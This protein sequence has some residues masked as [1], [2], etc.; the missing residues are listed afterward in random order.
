MGGCCAV[1]MFDGSVL[2][3]ARKGGMEA[4]PYCCPTLKLSLDTVASG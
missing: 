4:G 3:N 1:E 2:Y